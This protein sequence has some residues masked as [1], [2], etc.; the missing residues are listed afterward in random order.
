MATGKEVEYLE[1]DKPFDARVVQQVLE[2]F[3]DLVPEA[4]DVLQL[5]E[6]HEIPYVDKRST[7]GAL[8]MIGGKELHV[9]AQKAQTLGLTFR[10][11]AGGGKVTKGKDAWWAK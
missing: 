3:E 8:W 10:F 2:G 11:R 5:L 1:P 7:G 4:D 9:V 6:L